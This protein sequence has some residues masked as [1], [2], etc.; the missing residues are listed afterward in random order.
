MS[1]TYTADHYSATAHAVAEAIDRSKSH[2]EIVTLECLRPAI[3]QAV[4][5]ELAL[6]CEDSCLDAAPGLSEFWGRDVNG[7]EWRVHVRHVGAAERGRS[8][9][10]WS[11]D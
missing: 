3:A 6:E 8:V 5:D 9:R 1:T 2:D 7:A 4:L 11:D 10:G